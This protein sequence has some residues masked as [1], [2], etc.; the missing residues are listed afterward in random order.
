MSAQ[1]CRPLHFP[2]SKQGLIRVDFSFRSLDHYSWRI[3]LMKMMHSGFSRMEFMWKEL[4]LCD[5]TTV[6]VLEKMW[7]SCS[8]VGFFHCSTHFK[9][10]GVFF[11]LAVRLRVFCDAGGSQHK[12][13]NNT[14]TRASDLASSLFKV[15]SFRAG[16]GS[17]TYRQDMHIT[18]TCYYSAKKKKRIKFTRTVGSAFFC[19]KL[20]LL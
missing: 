1:F 18:N 19:D 7:N 15:P 13:R 2:A 6:N 5:H 8:G 20:I 16:L 10:L 4:N 9:V 12:L 17:V 11:S 3:S 14:M